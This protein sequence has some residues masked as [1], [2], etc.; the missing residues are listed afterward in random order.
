L[1][2]VVQQG[3]FEL[4]WNSGTTL[5]IRTTNLRFEDMFEQ[6]NSFALC[7][8]VTDDTMKYHQKLYVNEFYLPSYI[9]FWNSLRAA[10]P[11]YQLDLEIAKK[12]NFFKRAQNEAL[13]ALVTKISF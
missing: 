13:R 10:S 9:N 12:S 5:K 8:L 11:K 1:Y 3:K 7:L 4:S 6:I 2:E